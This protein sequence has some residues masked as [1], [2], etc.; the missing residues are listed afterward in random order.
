MANS[1]AFYIE[2]REQVDEILAEFGANFTI[3][4]S[5]VYDETTLTTS[6]ATTREV[7]GVVGSNFISSSIASMISAYSVATSNTTGQTTKSLILTASAA[8]VDGEE[9]YVDGKWHSLKEAEKVKPA[10]ITVVYVL[11]LIK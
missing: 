4:T 3:R 8:P 2:L 10:D 5:G 6:E 9:I 11:D 1:D 7:V